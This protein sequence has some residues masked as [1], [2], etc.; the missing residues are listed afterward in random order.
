MAGTGETSDDRVMLSSNQ[1]QAVADN[2]GKIWRQVEKLRS[3]T[4]DRPARIL[5]QEEL[6]AAVFTAHIDTIVD[7][8]SA[9]GYAA[10][11]IGET[12]AITGGITLMSFV[13]DLFEQDNGDRAAHWLDARWDGVTTYGSS[14]L[15]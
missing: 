12:L 2:L 3:K 11:A 10:F 1:L 14:W 8:E 6:S 9:M 13:M 15:S 7:A 5:T 4:E